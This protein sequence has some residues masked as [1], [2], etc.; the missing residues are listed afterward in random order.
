VLHR[1]R[2]GTGSPDDR[3]IF[4]RKLD[5]LGS[6]AWKVA[7]EAGEL[8]HTYST[9]S[10]GVDMLNGAYH[11]LDLVP[12]GRDESGLNPTTMGASPRSI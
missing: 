9:Y 7:H 11:Y 3:L 8:F 1:L 6:A 4:V 10:R 12:K 2:L 5:I